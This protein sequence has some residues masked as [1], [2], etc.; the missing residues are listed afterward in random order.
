MNFTVIIRC[1]CDTLHTYYI[2][3]NMSVC[4]CVSVSVKDSSPCMYHSSP[5]FHW[6]WNSSIWLSEAVWPVSQRGIPWLFP[7]PSFSIGGMDSKLLVQ[8][9]M[10]VLGIWTRSLC[11]C[12]RH[13]INWDI[14]LVL[15]CSFSDRERSEKPPWKITLCMFVHTENSVL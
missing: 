5:G 8:F 15:E 1:V 6:A 9:F 11:L 13:F 12:G 7:C 2:C 3:V 14:F 4:R 10:W